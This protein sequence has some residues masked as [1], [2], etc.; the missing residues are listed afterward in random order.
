MTI[1]PADALALI[2]SRQ[3]IGQ[4]VEPAPQPEQLAQAIQAAL[5]A[6]DHH[7]LRPWSFICIQGDEARTAFGQAL[8][9]ALKASGETD[10]VQWER[11]QAQPFRAPMILACIVKT[12]IHPKVPVVEQVLSMG[13]AVQ[14]LLLVLTAQGYAGM[15][16][17]GALVESLELKQALGVA[18]QDIIAGLVYIGT[19]SRNLTARERLPVAEFLH[20]W[21]M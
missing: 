4:L 11:V 2:E 14:N 1:S 12:Q 20:H 5:S 10:A 21:P 18:Q 13:A 17:S 15:W 19:P 7:R 9:S 8:L 6:P 3:S 16:R